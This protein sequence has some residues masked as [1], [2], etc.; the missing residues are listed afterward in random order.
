[1]TQNAAHEHLNSSDYIKVGSERSFGVVFAILFA[2]IGLYPLIYESPVHLW[3]LTATVGFLI[4]S[5]IFPSA[6]RPLNLLWFK[7]G[8]LLHKVANPLIMGIMFFVVITPIG[9]LMRSLG[10]D[11]LQKKFNDSAKTY[12]INRD[13]NA[14][15][16]KN[17]F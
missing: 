16:M 6:L 1:M 9:L 3:A 11:L 4:A 8:L 17:Q 5:L 14:G 10:K 7:F 15:S 2:I 12:W 13:K